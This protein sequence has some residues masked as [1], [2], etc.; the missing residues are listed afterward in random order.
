MISLLAFLLIYKFSFR[1]HHSQYEPSKPY[2]PLIYP[3]HSERII[4][5]Y[6]LI[7][8]LKQQKKSQLLRFLINFSIIL[9]TFLYQLLGNFCFCSALMNVLSS[10]YV[11]TFNK[12][13]VGCPVASVEW[14]QV[15]CLCLGNKMKVWFNHLIGWQLICGS[16]FRTFLGD[17][18]SC[19][20]PIIVNCI[21]CQ[22]ILHCLP[23]GQSSVD[24]VNSDNN[25]DGQDSS[26][27]L[28]KVLS[29][30]TV[31]L[32]YHSLGLALWFSL[33]PR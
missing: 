7:Y 1:Y 10:V 31:Y 32:I 16:I 25:L 22:R 23:Q 2:L 24:G 3:E 13:L 33:F 29:A 12:R 4:L 5:D 18:I 8:N 9:K 30:Y 11:P 21:E 17:W 6:F 14:K 20:P 27:A 19:V 15:T 28:G 26:C